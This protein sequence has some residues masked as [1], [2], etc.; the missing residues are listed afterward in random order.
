MVTSA[1]GDMGSGSLDQERRY[2][3]ASPPPGSL[4]R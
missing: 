2:R 1:E 4:A 3:S